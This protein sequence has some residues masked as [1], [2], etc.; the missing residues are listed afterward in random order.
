M[1]ND[2]KPKILII[3]GTTRE[4]R[5]GRK[6]ADWYL[7]EARLSASEMD[8]ELFD[9]DD[10][11]LPL[12]NE[13][14]P[15][16]MH[17]YSPLQKKMAEKIGKADGFVFVTGEYNHSIPGSMKNFIDYLNT[18]WNYKAAA[19]VGYGGTGAIRAIEHLIQVMTELKVF[20]VA[21]TF[22]NILINQVWAAFDQEGKPKEGFVHGN[23]VNQLK[24]L[25]WW[26]NAL[27]DARKN[28]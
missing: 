3:V 27:K 28:K 22:D 12:F 5:L 24:E 23:I 17:K 7:K 20:S 25:T 13:A 4:G 21:N 19:Y 14:M 16:L 15:P 18:E 1:T 10:W 11:N 26:I 6:V 2:N 9:V 8:L